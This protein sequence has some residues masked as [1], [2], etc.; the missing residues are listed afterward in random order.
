MR[1]EATPAAERNGITMMMTGK[2][3][4]KVFHH[5]VMGTSHRRKGIP[6]Q[7]ASGSLDAG[8]MKIATVADG[9][10]DPTCLRSDAGSAIAV[11][12]ALKCLKEFGEYYPNLESV[13][14]EGRCCCDHPECLRQLTDAIVSQWS[15]E[16]RQHLEKHPLTEEEYAGAGPFEARYRQGEYVERIYGSTLVAALEAEDY[17]LLLQQGDGRCDLL[18]EDGT[19]DQPIPE[20]ERCYGNVTTSMSDDLAA[21][22]IRS[23]IVPLNESAPVAC[24]LSTDGVDN[25]FYEEEEILHFYLKTGT[26][27]LDSSEEDFSAV[28]EPI[29]NEVSFHGN[30]DDVSLAG[31]LDP[32]RFGEAEQVFREVIQK[33]Q[34]DDVRAQIA[35]KLISMER[36]MEVLQGAVRNASP[37]EQEARMKEYMEYRIQYNHMRAKAEELSEE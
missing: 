14:A 27:L 31:W 6:C 36:K 22:E 20:D 37:E 10:G 23:V 17:L 28:L 1:R 26:R 11:E 12:T 18:R 25:G 30:G 33:N 29:L 2:S 35:S 4:K 19:M 8:R 24:L 21:K 9:H 7:D 15:V 3:A 32:V 16:V 5:S 13:E 34:R